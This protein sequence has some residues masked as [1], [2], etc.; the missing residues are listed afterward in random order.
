MGLK[1]DGEEREEKQSWGRE[2]GRGMLSKDRR[3]AVRWALSAAAS[4]CCTQP[5]V[6]RSRA[7]LVPGRLF[8][9]S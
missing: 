4:A 8:V 5:R 7:Q 1:R 6:L 9:W 3:Q 2:V